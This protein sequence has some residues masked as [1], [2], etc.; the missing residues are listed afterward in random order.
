MAATSTSANTA[1][2]TVPTLPSLTTPSFLHPSFNIA[3]ILAN[4]TTRTFK[5]SRATLPD[6]NSYVALTI[7]VTDRY[8]RPY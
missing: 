3:H 6:S 8:T 4:Y 7:A 5:D 2:A 1:S